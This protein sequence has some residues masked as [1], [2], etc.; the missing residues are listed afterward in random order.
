MKK[1][2]TI[3]AIAALVVAGA[4]IGQSSGYAQGMMGDGYRGSHQG[5]QGRGMGKGQG[6]GRGHGMDKG[7]GQGKGRGMGNHVR[8][9]VI[10]RG[11]GVP[12]AYQNAK[13][14]LPATPQNIAAGQQLYANQCASCHGAKGVG[15]GEAGRGLSPKPANIAFV[16]DKPIATDAFLA[17]TL[18]EGGASLKTAMPA[19]KDVLSDK[20]RWQLIHYLRAGLGK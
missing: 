11:A 16:M 1:M 15:D 19:F 9:R 12:A 7:M 10:M 3:T 20:E 2:K 4:F 5:H 6:M 17:W 18:A 13:N 14:P 8:H